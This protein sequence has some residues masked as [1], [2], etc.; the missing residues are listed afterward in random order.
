MASVS[1]IRPI[2]FDNDKRLP[3]GQS[4]IVIT[5]LSLLCWAL[6]GFLVY[7]IIAL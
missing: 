6:L 7:G 4:A 1:H 5:G 3:R 2:K